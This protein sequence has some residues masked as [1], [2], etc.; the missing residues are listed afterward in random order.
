MCIYVQEIISS[1]KSVLY[2]FFIAY[3][4]LVLNSCFLI[5]KMYSDMS[6]SHVN[7]HIHFLTYTLFNLKKSPL[8]DYFKSLEDAL[9]NLKEKN[10][11]ISNLK[12]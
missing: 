3:L 8:Q 10:M 11:E 4:L 7:F 1:C 2:I 12:G 5:D 6:H 9:E